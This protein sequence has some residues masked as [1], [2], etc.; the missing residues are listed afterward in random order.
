MTSAVTCRAEGRMLRVMTKHAEQDDDRQEQTPT[1][2]LKVLNSTHVNKNII[3]S[4]LTYTSLMP[5][6][7]PA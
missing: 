2:A 6:Q 5:S 7:T 3:V 4:L 1:I